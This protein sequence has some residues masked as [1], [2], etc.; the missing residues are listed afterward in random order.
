MDKI[1]PWRVTTDSLLN[2]T[3]IFSLHKVKAHSQQRSGVAGEFVYLDAPNWVNVIAVTPEQ[4]IVLVQQYRHGTRT[5]TTEIPG[6]MCDRGEN[7]I[8]AG[9]RELLEETGYV[10]DA[11]KVIGVVHPNPAF[12]NN[13]CATV[14]VENAVAKQAQQL[15]PNEEICLLTIPLCEIPDKIRKGEITNSLVIAVFHMLHLHQSSQ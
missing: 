9:C 3:R 1:F 8:T 11:A 12:Q 4:E 2:N 6:G 14:L 10:G 7:F 15:D 13:S 5:I